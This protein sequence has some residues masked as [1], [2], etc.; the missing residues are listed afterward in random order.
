LIPIASKFVIKLIKSYFNSYN[1]ILESKLRKK[2]LRHRLRKLS[3]NKVFISDGEFKHTN[4]KVI[5][6]LYLFNR[7]KYNY[8]LKIKKKYIRLFKKTNFLKKLYLI[9]ILGLNILKQQEEKIKLLENILPNYFKNNSVLNS[10]MSQKAIYLQDQLLDR[11]KP[12]S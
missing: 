6:T 9:K 4:D 7:Q 3:I 2:R 8:L 1:S 12:I 11:D 5:I 10:K